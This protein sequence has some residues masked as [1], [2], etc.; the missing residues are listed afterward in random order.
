MLLG[1][2]RDY[3]GRVLEEIVSPVNGYAMYGLAGPPVKAGEKRG[4]HRVAGQ[5]A[6]VVPDRFTRLA[7][8]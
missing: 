8:R 5:G 6:V 3:A 4:H 7:A 1:T 2:V